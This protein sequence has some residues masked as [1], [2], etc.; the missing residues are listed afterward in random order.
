MSQSTMI[1][2][3]L[4]IIVRS[5]DI[6]FNRHVNNAKY[7]E[8]MEWG[9]EDFYQLAGAYYDTL[10]DLGV[11]TVAANVNLNYRKE[12]V[13]DDELIVITRPA[14]IGTSS[15]TVG[16]TIIRARDDEL[17]ADAFVTLVAM[18]VNTRRSTPV[19]DLLR[20]AF[21]T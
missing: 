15:F 18:D 16:Q 4:H 20:H 6:D 13:Q 11:I 21:L 5:T 9:R 19:P 2:S 10:L 12:A 1:E 17:I 7:L 8:Y 3:R 14:R